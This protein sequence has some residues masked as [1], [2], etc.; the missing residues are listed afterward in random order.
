[1]ADI[2]SLQFYNTHTS[3]VKTLNASEQMSGQSVCSIEVIVAIIYLNRFD[4]NNIFSCI[5]KRKE[6]T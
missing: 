1:M 2:A 6:R 4:S 3:K 5:E